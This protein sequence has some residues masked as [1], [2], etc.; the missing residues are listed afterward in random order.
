MEKS[1][2]GKEVAPVE[3]FLFQLAHSSEGQLELLPD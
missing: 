1:W 3:Q 2:N